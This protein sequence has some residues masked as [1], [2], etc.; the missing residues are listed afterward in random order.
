MGVEPRIVLIKK[1]GSL[2]RASA[3]SILI[4]LTAHM[5]RAAYAL[6]FAGVTSFGAADPDY[7]KLALN[8]QRLAND[9]QTFM[10]QKMGIAGEK[11]VIKETTP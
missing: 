6:N 5:N 2:D 10:S 7:N 8:L 3:H 11:R 1:P 9:L 4:G